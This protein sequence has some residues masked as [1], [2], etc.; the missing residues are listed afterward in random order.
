MNANEAC[1]TPQV[2]RLT[3]DTQGGQPVVSKEEYLAATMTV[4]PT[5]GAE[6]TLPLRIRGRGNSTWYA[7]KKP[8]LLNLDKKA[9]ILGMPTNKKWVLLASYYDRSLLRNAVVFC[10]AR[11]LKM[12]YTP[13][14]R[15]IELTM[16]GEYMGVY[17]IT[18]KN[19]EI[20]NL[21]EDQVKGY[22]AGAEFDDPFLIEVN[23]RRDGDFNI[24]TQ[25]QV[26]YSFESDSST[27]Q[28]ER[29]KAWLDTLEE[30]LLQVPAGPQ[31]LAQVEQRMDLQSLADLYLVNEMV[32]NVDAF[33]SS[34]FLY[35]QRGGL[36]SYGPVWDFDLAINNAFEGP[37]LPSGW[38]V[39]G[40]DYNWYF[41]ELLKEPEFASMV[42]Q[43]WRELSARAADL[44]PFIDRA[45]AALNDAQTRNIGRWPMINGYP[46][47]PNPADPRNYAN[48]V[49]NMADWLK[50]RVN[51][52][53]ENIE[54]ISNLQ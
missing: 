30:I 22:I 44:Q 42:V 7:E 49:A 48:E 2:A 19:Y 53:D 15:F 14:D 23:D 21:V 52:L 6:V 25:S 29:V 16:N 35:R 39:R 20:R 36:L 37:Q 13:H 40:K 33:F 43:R 28:A 12:P 17:Q 10:A 54:Q 38:L 51:W 18:D 11:L 32:G 4:T 27:A 34:T 5:V 50:Q 46:A 3:I 45:A 31:R 8:Y 26:P 1:P 47:W 24:L 9:E 41:R